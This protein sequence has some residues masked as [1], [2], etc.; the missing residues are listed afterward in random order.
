MSIHIF[1]FIFVYG[2]VSEQNDNHF[3]STNVSNHFQLNLYPLSQASS[4]NFGSGTS[5]NCRQKQPVREK[6]DPASTMQKTGLTNFSSFLVRFGLEKDIT[7][8]CQHYG[9]LKKHFP[10]H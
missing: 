9:A 10:V 3:K 2:K 5:K 7:C 4:E 8:G 6:K 1:L